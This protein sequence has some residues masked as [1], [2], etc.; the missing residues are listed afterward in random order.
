[1]L[2]AR[3]FS[4]IVL[5]VGDALR[6]LEAYQNPRH[7][8]GT[9]CLFIITE[10]EKDEVLLERSQRDVWR[11]LRQIQPAVFVPDAG[12]VYQG[13]SPEEQRNGVRAYR[14]RLEKVTTRVRS[15]NWTIRILPLLKGM[16]QSHFEMLEDTF[17]RFGF[18]EAAFY[19]AP[20]SG[21]G[22]VFR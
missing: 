5:N 13:H 6:M 22:V 18:E 4:V 15:E 3:L 11:L 9:D 12:M 16:R 19:G 20:Y 1:V 8:I 14:D 17:E 7:L 21:Q 2:Q 10:T